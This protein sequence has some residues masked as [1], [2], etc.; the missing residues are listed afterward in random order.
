MLFNVDK[1]NVMHIG[2]NNQKTH[3]VLHGKISNKVTE[4]RDLGVIV[5]DD[6]KWSKQ[7]KEVVSKAN[8]MLGLIKHNFID[9]SQ[10]T[11][12]SFY[13]SMVQ[14]HLKYCSQIWSP[15]YMKD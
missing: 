9:R 11:I 3:Y 5:S 2:H 4:E 10:E 1:C 14:P 8:S 7:C 13:K 6:L 15:H 12:I